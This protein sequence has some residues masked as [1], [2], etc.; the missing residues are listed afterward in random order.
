LIVVYT[1]PDI[2]EL[3]LNFSLLVRIKKV[4]GAY[5]KCTEQKFDWRRYEMKD[6]PHAG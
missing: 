6:G 2:L 3:A 1:D 4:G 5:A